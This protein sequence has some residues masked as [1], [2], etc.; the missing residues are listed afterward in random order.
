MESV[1]VIGIGC[2]AWTV[3]EVFRLSSTSVTVAMPAAG[4][5]RMAEA[6]SH[7]VSPK[8][9]SPA[10]VSRSGKAPRFAAWDDRGRPVT[11]ED[12]GRA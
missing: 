9:P 6:P 3:I 11:V 2:V 12:L 1:F 4:A 7:G 10:R 8:R 5:Q